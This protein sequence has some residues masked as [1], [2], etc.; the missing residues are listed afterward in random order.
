MTTTTLTMVGMPPAR[1][2]SSEEC[3][4]LARAGIID[5]GEQADVLAGHRRFTVDEYLAMERA[6]ILH[7]DDRIE[8]IDG[9]TVIMPPIGDPHEA[10]TDWLTRLFVPSLI[11]R[12]IIR[13]QGAI[14]LN[15]RSAPQP[16]IAVLR[17]RPLSELGPY[18]PPDVHL[19]IEVADSSLAYDQGAKLARYAAAGITEVWVANLRAQEVTSYSEPNGAEYAA[20]RT[21]RAGENISPR[22]FPDVVLAVSDFMPP[23]GPDTAEAP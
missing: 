5:A 2:F 17:E 23:A 13:V 10:C 22:A 16:D 9:E 19:V 18:F 7:E 14:R 15:D 6:G 4:A 11:G 8:L 21:Y 1:P 20:V 12:A 3:A